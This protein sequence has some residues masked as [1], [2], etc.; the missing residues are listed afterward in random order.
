MITTNKKLAMT[1]VLLNT[2]LGDG[3]REY[4]SLLRV[5]PKG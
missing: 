2:D 4:C 5:F 3:V 1:T